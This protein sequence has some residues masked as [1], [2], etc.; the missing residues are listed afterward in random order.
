MRR[1]R[2]SE[3]LVMAQIPRSFA[4]T[5]QSLLIM[6]H[7]NDLHRSLAPT[8]IRAAQATNGGLEDLREYTIKLRELYQRLWLSENYP[9]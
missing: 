9:T 7:Q 5:G 3:E 1:F 2:F 6:A 8:G 4:L